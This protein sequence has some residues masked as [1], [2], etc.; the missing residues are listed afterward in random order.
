MKPASA[1]CHST[2]APCLCE[3]YLVLSVPKN[4]ICLKVSLRQSTRAR[5][6]DHNTSGVFLPAYAICAQVTHTACMWFAWERGMRS[7]L[8]RELIARTAILQGGFF[9]KHSPLSLRQ[10]GGSARG[11]RSEIEWRD[12]RRA[13]LYL[14]HYLSDPMTAPRDWKPARRILPLGQRPQRFSCLLLRKLT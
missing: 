11:V 14:H 5:N 3:S 9:H 8:S 10:S 2:S 6:A 13:S 7:R 1:F 4:K 12:R